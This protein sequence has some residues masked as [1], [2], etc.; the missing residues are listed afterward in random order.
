MLE[1]KEFVGPSQVMWAKHDEVRQLFREKDPTKISE[2]LTQVEDMIFK[3]ESIL[4]PTSMEL[5]T[6]LDW[7]TVKNGEEEIGFAWVTPGDEWKPLTPDII[8][9]KELVP[10]KTEFMDLDTGKLSLEQLNLLLTHLPIEISFINEQDEVR[11]YS[12]T[13]ERLFPRSP[14]VIGRKVQQC[15]PPKSVDK[16]EKIVKAFK[17]GKKDHADFWITMNEKFLH[18][19]YFAVRDKSGLYKGTLEVMQDVTEIRQLQGEQ[20]LINWEE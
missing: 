15:H 1:K 14:G 4:Y 20:R 17:A 10:E 12:D 13:K 16:V 6:S 2:I 5:L 8:H 9:Q 19:R 18:I 11:Y 7:Q 3:E